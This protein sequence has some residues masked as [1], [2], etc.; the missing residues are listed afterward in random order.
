MFLMNEKRHNIRKFEN[1][2]FKVLL[3]FLAVEYVKIDESHTNKSHE[4]TE[5]GIFRGGR[6]LQSKA[7]LAL[8]VVLVDERKIL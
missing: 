1:I 4:E 2:L 8:P 6:L 7:I 3:V 5:K